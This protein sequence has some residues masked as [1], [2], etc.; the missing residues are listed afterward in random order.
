MFNS[1]SNYEN[2]LYILNREVLGVESVDLSYSNSAVISKILGRNSSFTTVGGATSQQL[3]VSRNLIYDDPIYPY[4]N[5]DTLEG[6]IV[7]N[8]QAF[9]FYSGYLTD[10]I[11][12]CAVGA[13]PKVSTNFVIFDEITTGALPAPKTQD[14]IIY[15]PNQGSI[16]LICDH[17]STNRVVGFDYSIKVSK[18]PIYILGSKTPYE[19]VTVAPNEYSASVQIDVDD[20]FLQNSFN[21]LLYREDK[22][23]VFSIKD[24]T[25]TNTIQTLT[26][27]N[28]SLVS[29]SLSSSADGGVKLTLNYIGHS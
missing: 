10:Y 23:V 6:Q 5:G 24:R 21:F 28:A 1:T 12:N 16:S 11:V 22:T 13:I 9:G 14:T 25:L 7:Y 20:A 4:I 15:I 8:N 3:S 17:S 18:K 29:E 2:T 26:I 19:V 27:P